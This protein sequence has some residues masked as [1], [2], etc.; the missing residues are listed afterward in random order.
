M[1]DINPESAL[2]Q[3]MQSKKENIILT[4]INVKEGMPILFYSNIM[5][6]DNF[7]KTLPM[8]MNLSSEVLA[9]VDKLNLKFAKEVQ[10]NINSQISEF[11][12]ITKKVKLY[13][14]DANFAK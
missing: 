1:F 14:Y 9:D 12:V 13:E 4:R 8:G 11:K 5:F 2:S 7:N 10:F 6:Y 3:V